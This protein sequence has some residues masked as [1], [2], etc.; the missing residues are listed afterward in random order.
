MLF[1]I[2]IAFDLYC[3]F[4]NTVTGLSSALYIFGFTLFLDL[5]V[6]RLIII[7]GLSVAQTVIRKMTHTE[8]YHKVLVE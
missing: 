1:V 2:G 4:N 8:V 3:I 6:L 7:A 5:L